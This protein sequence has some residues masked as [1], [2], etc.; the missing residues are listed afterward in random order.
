MRTNSTQT[1]VLKELLKGDQNMLITGDAGTGKSWVVR[2]F[3]D[4]LP[5][6]TRIITVAPTGVAAQNIGG[7]TIHSVFQIPLSLPKPRDMASFNAKKLKT[8]KRKLME[9]LEILLIDEVSMVRGDVYDYM[10]QTLRSVRVSDLPFG[11]VRVIHVGDP[12]QLPPVVLKQETL[13]NPWFFQTQAWKLAEVQV[14]NLTEQKR[15][16]GDVEFAQLLTRCR[17]GSPNVGDMS[18]LRLRVTSS[19]PSEHTIILSPTNLRVAQV[20]EERLERIHGPIHKFEADVKIQD[21]T[22]TLTKSRVLMQVMAEELLELKVGARVLM[23]NNNS[24]GLWVNGSMGIVKLISMEIAEDEDEENLPSE[25]FID[26][27][28]DGQTSTVRVKKHTWKFE[29]TTCSGEGETFGFTK[30]TLAEIIQFPLKLGYALTVHKSQGLSFDNV[31]FDFS[32]IFEHGQAY[33]AMSRCR[34]LN[35]LTLSRQIQ[36]KSITANPH[37]VRFMR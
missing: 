26:V 3:L 6:E 7:E 16:A 5:K 30:R 17:Y 8:E 15:Q 11:G 1:E 23:L 2:K 13:E 21:K 35:G 19:E 27:L 18:K 4:E 33:V 32:W 31:H 24:N 10:D 28:L 29:E 22:S 36:A 34:S 37:V 12:F 9:E 25:P 20:N 14:F